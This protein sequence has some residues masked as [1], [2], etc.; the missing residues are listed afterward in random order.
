MPSLVHQPKRFLQQPDPWLQQPHVGIWT[1]DQEFWSH[2]LYCGMTRCGKTISMLNS[3]KKRYEKEQPYCQQHDIEPSYTRVTVIDPKGSQ[4]GGYETVVDLDGQSC[5]VRVDESDLDTI[6]QA[7]NKLAFFSGEVLPKRR[8]TRM[9][10][11]RHGQAYNPR[12]HIIIIEEWLYLL[13]IASDYDFANNLKGNASLEQK[14]IRKVKSLVRTGLED[15]VQIWLSTQEPNVD[16]NKFSAAFRSNFEYYCFGSPVRGYDSIEIALDARYNI[17]RSAEARKKLGQKLE[18]MSEAELWTTLAISG[19][20]N[21]QKTSGPKIGRT[22]WI[23][24]SIK[25]Q[26]FIVGELATAEDKAIAAAVTGTAT[27]EVESSPGRAVK[28]SGSNVIDF[29]SPGSARL[30]KGAQRLIDFTR[31]Q[32][33]SLSRIQQA[34]SRLGLSWNTAEIV[35]ELAQECVDAGEARLVENVG[36]PG[37]YRFELVEAEAEQE[38][39]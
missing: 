19:D 6:L 37:S 23:D 11:Y 20:P 35:K 17:V 15:G 27:V 24:D 8:R 12:P 30:S 9:D 33:G 29:P 22:P 14:L 21:R 36:Y 32:G 38:A 5:V 4:W 16:A 25:R 7:Y 28:P 34:Y 3:L 2:R 13:D 31:K 18:E 1:P 10:L 39:N 26:Q